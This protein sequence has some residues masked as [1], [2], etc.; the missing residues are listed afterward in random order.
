[1]SFLDTMIDSN[2]T[3]FIE[4]FKRAG[5]EAAAPESRLRFSDLISK[6][7]PGFADRNPKTTGV[8]GFIGDVG[9]DPLTYIGTPAVTGGKKFLIGGMS[10]TA[11]YAA[12]HAGSLE[13]SE[14]A[15]RFLSRA[16]GKH[17]QQV[18]VRL[19]KKGMEMATDLANEALERGT[20][21]TRRGKQIAAHEVR[22]LRR[23]GFSQ[24]D[25]VKLAE[26]RVLQ[27]H[28][29]GTM[30]AQATGPSVTRFDRHVAQ[31][32]KR[33]MS[34]DDAI[35]DTEKAFDAMRKEN[36]FLS[37]RMSEGQPLAERV[38]PQL[39]WEAAETKITRLLGASPKTA[40]K[41]IDTGGISFAGKKVLDGA[42]IRKVN[43][44]VGITRAREVLHDSLIGTAFRRAFSKADVPAG[45]IKL[46]KNIAMSLEKSAKD[47]SQLLTGP[48]AALNKESREKIGRLMTE[49]DS[50]TAN[51]GR[52]AKDAQRKVNAAQAK[53]AEAE[54]AAMHPGSFMNAQAANAEVEKA[55]QALAAVEGPIPY[56]PDKLRHTMIQD[57]KLTTEEHSALAQFYQVMHQLGRDETRVGL[58]QSLR[59]NYFPR[60]WDVIKGGQQLSGI[61]QKLHRYGDMGLFGPGEMRKFTTI[62][63]ARKAGFDPVQDAGVVMALRVTDHHQ[64]LAK[65]MFDDSAGQVTRQLKRIA[66]RGGLSPRAHKIAQ[67]RYDYAKRYVQFVGEGDYSNFS[68]KEV[69]AALTFY[70]K[71][72]STFRTFATVARPAFGVRQ[73]F[74]N[75]F[76]MFIG[77]GKNAIRHLWDPRSTMDAGAMLSGNASKIRMKSVLGMDYTGDDIMALAQKHDIL[78]NVTVDGVGHTPIVNHHTAPK[79]MKEIHRNYRVKQKV[80]NVIGKKGA[81]GMT[82]F[83]TNNL[84]YTHFPAAVEDFS[85]L[86]MFTNMLRA[87]HSP[88]A[89]AKLVDD[90]L[91]DYLHGLSQIERRVMRRI[92]PFYSFQ[93]FAVPLI[94]QAAVKAPGR[95][96]NATNA[97]RLLME[98]YG[99]MGNNEKLTQA[100]REVIPGWILDQPST[101][102]GFDDEMKAVF[103][104]FNNFTPL[105]VFGY[106]QEDE[107]G[108]FDTRRTL[109]QGSLSQLTP[110]VKVPMEAML[111]DDFFTGRS[112]DK[113]RNIGD[114]DV[115]KVLGHIAGIAIAG[116]KAADGTMMKGW[117]GIAAGKLLGGMLSALP[118]EAQKEKV[119]SFLGI[120]EGVDKEGK[121]TVYMNAYALHILTSF[122]PALQEGFKLSREDKTPWEKTERFLFGVPSFK[123]DLKQQKGAKMRE[124]QRGIQDRKYDMRSA[125]IQQRMK[126]YE[127][128]KLDL[129]QWMADWQS[130]HSRLMKGDPLRGL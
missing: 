15:L 129:T 41:I 109:L 81:E 108:K 93:R 55:R 1:M 6:Y 103:K 91:F 20:L 74:S 16:G 69:R 30:L 73:I 10:R 32:M 37:K 46:H 40:A 53:L 19:N 92:V 11:K 59:Q 76:Q 27:L 12:K 49:I 111:G 36:Y 61:R 95:I 63:E 33:G 127:R 87:G 126:A 65:Q 88:E 3:A 64:A 97:G 83:F 115:D 66:D 34:M 114:V 79:L 107:T 67:D 43:D 80:E 78:R 119:A 62:D 42:T 71:A 118:M 96:K 38:T 2:G 13:K 50:K 112:L 106:M 21:L 22:R 48:M 89:A 105:D 5:Q 29:K 101:F 104:T 125:K 98:T 75:H 102:A 52:G 100:E 84:N 4:A 117:G 24:A 51:L 47:V 110:F 70:D 8:L 82:R 72:M 85:R 90:A 99:K 57:A 7:S 56:N 116:S 128:A 23:K 18:G 45:L 17:G 58:V 14:R 122:F 86:Q 31:R 54:Q 94:M 68:E 28:E 113:A 35:I 130:D 60:Y 120:E 77:G 121:R 26:T 39:A 123:T 44:A 9:L 124:F 25:A